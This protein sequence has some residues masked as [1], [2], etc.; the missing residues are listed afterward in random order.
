MQFTSIYF[1]NVTFMKPLSK[2]V[3]EEKVEVLFHTVTVVENEILVLDINNN[4]N[5]RDPI[6]RLENCT[7]EG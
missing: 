6:F 5:T 7:F 1:R 3:F 2:M 4:I